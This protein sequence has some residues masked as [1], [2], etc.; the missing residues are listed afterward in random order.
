MFLS[1]YYIHSTVKHLELL[2]VPSSLPHLP[3]SLHSTI[4]RLPFPPH[5]GT[6]LLK[7]TS[8]L[9]V[10]KNRDHFPNSSNSTSQ[11]PPHWKLSSFVIDDPT[12]SWFSYYTQVSPPQSHLPGHHLL[13][14]SETWSV[15]HRVQTLF[16][17]ILSSFLGSHPVTWLQLPSTSTDFQG[18]PPLQISPIHSSGPSKCLTDVA[19][20]RPSRGLKQSSN[21]LPQSCSSFCLLHLSNGIIIYPV[22]KPK[23]TILS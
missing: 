6:A 18:R 12:V 23:S 19:T 10:A 8:E 11:P 2:I 20:S 3:S 21:F 4:S 16:L 15:P 17:S 1:S 13:L 9:S 7:V 14:P 5:T 22:S